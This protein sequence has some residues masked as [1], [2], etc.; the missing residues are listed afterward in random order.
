MAKRVL[1]LDLGDA[2]CGHSIRQSD[3]TGYEARFASDY[4]L[5]V[6]AVREW[7]PDILI[8]TANALAA[9][10]FETIRDLA[11]NRP[12]APPLPLLPVLLISDICGIE[13]LARGIR[14]GVRGF[15][16]AG[17]AP[18]VIR[19][20]LGILIDG[21][22]YFGPEMADI[23]A[24][25]F[26]SPAAW[27]AGQDPGL[28]KSGDP[29]HH[30]QLLVEDAAAI[31]QLLDTLSDRVARHFTSL[32]M[33]SP[34]APEP[35]PAANGGGPPGPAANGGGRPGEA[36]SDPV[37]GRARVIAIAAVDSHD[38]LMQRVQECLDGI[39]LKIPVASAPG[40]VLV[41]A[42]ERAWRKVA[43]SFLAIGHPIHMGVSDTVTSRHDTD[44]GAADALAA[45]RR[46]RG[47]LAPPGS[48]LS[49][50][51]F[52]LSMWL[53]EA[54]HRVDLSR[55]LPPSF[56][57]LR[58]HPTLSATLIGWLVH[59]CDVR[60][61][62]TSMHV[63]PNTVRYRLSRVEEIVQRRISE[64]PVLTSLYLTA[65]AFPAAL[66]LPARSPL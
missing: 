51:E 32:L 50:A 60:R 24:G 41:T 39:G 54:A 3:L 31:P 19:S 29:D 10:D 63:H 1:V 36:A 28:A 4:G 25:H 23:L 42:P 34:P 16:R 53:A 15:L 55:R 21:G 52:T 58:E 11:G 59:D 7:Q 44:A 6:R 37:P 30:R 65:L 14:A 64:T 66:G 56:A 62:A 48:E 47:Q 43:L 33:Q 2:A 26:A 61:A 18:E 9:C 13:L 27:T 17:A 20:A 12:G 49:A 22:G 40:A 57:R 38:G 46:L 5:A 45:L 8:T 35:A